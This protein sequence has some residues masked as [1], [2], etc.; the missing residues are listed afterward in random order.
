MGSKKIYQFSF[1]KRLLFL[2][3][4][5]IVL[6]LILVFVL[7]FLVNKEPYEKQTVKKR[8]EKPSEGKKYKQRKTSLKKKTHIKDNLENDLPDVEFTFYD[9]L[10]R[11]ENSLSG[12]TRP[13]KKSSRNGKDSLQKKRGKREK[14]VFKKRQG[15]S[16]SLNGYTLQVG[17]FQSKEH[18]D[19][20]ANKLKKKGYAAYSISSNI[21]MKGTWHRV[22]VG[23][24]KTIEDAKK[25]ELMFERKERLSAYVTYIS[26]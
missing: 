26:E 6:V 21:P 25:V 9:I 14:D 15:K 3:L 19:G 23:H 16:G 1:S 7:G 17:S 24:F 22:R 2:M 5:G 10:S 13:K 11:K 4:M 12:Q 18:A 20:L 8:I